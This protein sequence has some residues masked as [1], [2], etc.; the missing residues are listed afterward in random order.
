MG[1]ELIRDFGKPVL[2]CDVQNF[3]KAHASTR[4]CGLEHGGETPCAEFRYLKRRNW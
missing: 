2:E 4:D 1:L 3:E